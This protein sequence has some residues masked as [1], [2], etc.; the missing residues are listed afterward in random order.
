MHFISYCANL[1]Y[2]D[3][4][5]LVADERYGEETSAF[6]A[7][8]SLLGAVSDFWRFISA[9]QDFSEGFDGILRAPGH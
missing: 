7:L 6:Q 3:A 4:N 5:T 2:L 1:G 8:L 9:A